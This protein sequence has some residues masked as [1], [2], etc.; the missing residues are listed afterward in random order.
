MVCF[1]KETFCFLAFTLF[2]PLPIKYQTPKPSPPPYSKIRQARFRVCRFI[3]SEKSRIL[4]SLLG[5]RP[6]IRVVP[7][8][9]PTR[10]KTLPFR[11]KSHESDRQNLFQ[12][13]SADSR[14]VLFPSSLTRR[15][16]LF[17]IQ[18]QFKRGELYGYNGTADT[19][20]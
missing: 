19:R 12:P 11:K 18:I 13:V 15:M 1:G 5:N 20:R 17:I 7:L 8:C 2:C 6:I 9:P 10:K 16:Y 14:F 4:R 3:C